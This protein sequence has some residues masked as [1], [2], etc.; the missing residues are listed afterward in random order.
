MS[1]TFCV[2]RMLLELRVSIKRFEFFIYGDFLSDILK[3]KILS[4]ILFVLGV[5]I[6]DDVFL[7]LLFTKNSSVY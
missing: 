7:L 5:G 6:S 4:A 2:A 1:E 3:K